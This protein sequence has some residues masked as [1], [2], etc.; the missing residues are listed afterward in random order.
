ME[1]EGDVEG[2]GNLRALGDTGL[3]NREADCGGIM[4]VDARNGFNELIHLAILWTV[5]HHW[6]AGE[7]FAFKIYRH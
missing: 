2:E 4:S 3:L 7:S 5:H 6:P 1:V